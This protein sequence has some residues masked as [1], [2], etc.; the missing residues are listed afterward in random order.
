MNFSVS[1]GVSHR[2]GQIGAAMNIGGAP[3]VLVCLL[4]NGLKRK[5]P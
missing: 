2:G 4:A 5:G 3:T 1:I